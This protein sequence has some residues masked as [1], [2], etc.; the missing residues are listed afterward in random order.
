LTWTA[1]VPL[2]SEAARKSRLAG[3][4]APADRIALSHALLGRLTTALRAVPRITSIVLL[5]DAPPTGWNERWIL[6]RDRGLNAELEEAR[7]RL[8]T[9]L[10][11]IHPDLPIVEPD[12]LEFLIDAAEETGCA[13]AP[14]R[15]GEGT[16]ALAIARPTALPFQFGVDSFARHCKTPGVAITGVRRLGLSLDCDTPDDLDR[17]IAEGF[18]AP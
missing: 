14:D 5:T 9:P 4:L 6:D 12:D 11:V 18:I 8:E 13:I 1:L 17:A 16:N 7:S 2:K 15:H 3:R 10:V